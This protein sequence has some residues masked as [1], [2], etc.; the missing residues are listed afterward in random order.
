[1]KDES[2]T[3]ARRSYSSSSSSRHRR[4]KTSRAKKPR[5]TISELEALLGHKSKRTHKRCMSARA[6][7]VRKYLRAHGLDRAAKANKSQ[8]STCSDWVRYLKRGEH[9]KYHRKHGKGRHSRRRSSSHNSSSRR[10]SSRNSSS[11]RSSSSSSHKKARKHRKSS[12]HSRKSSSQKSR[13]KSQKMLRKLKRMASVPKTA[14]S[15]KAKAKPLSRHGALTL[16]G[17]K[18]LD[19]WN[20]IRSSDQD[21]INRI[22]S[23]FRKKKTG[24]YAKDR[25]ALYKFLQRR[26]EAKAK[27]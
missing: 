14:T 5:L 3:M 11:R 8:S 9:R 27:K 4:S 2:I 24:N 13:S 18:R 7:D 1:M 15:A 22:L 26:K 20:K 21:E 17:R 16:I 10:S 19:Q 25:A 12:S 6:K 23:A